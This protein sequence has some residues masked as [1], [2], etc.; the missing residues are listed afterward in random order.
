V[1]AQLLALGVALAGDGD[2]CALLRQQ[3]SL[4]T[5]R[6]DPGAAALR[7]EIRRVCDDDGR[8]AGGVAVVTAPQRRVDP[9]TD[10][11]ARLRG[12]V[13]ELRALGG[14]V[15]P[16]RQLLVGC[17]EVAVS[18][19]VVR[20]AA[21]VVTWSFASAVRTSG[22]GNRVHPILHVVRFHDGVDLDADAGD[23]LPALAAGVVVF[24]GSKRGYGLS[25]EI[26]HASGL[27]TFYAHNARV[28]VEVGQRVARGEAIAE[29]GRGG[30]STGVHV[31]LE[32]R[33]DGRA[34]D[35]TPYLARP[36][37]LEAHP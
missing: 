3:A 5:G 19:V 27:R 33:R 14:D 18:P 26:E 13:D 25:V 31:H 32:V 16:W 22:F 21:P 4:A 30:L 20:R 29:A 2:A 12:E 6:G 35:P 11:C 24:T 28:F 36:D 37:R 1:I 8:H 34:I 23:V 15:T 7:E 10:R 17:P 9:T